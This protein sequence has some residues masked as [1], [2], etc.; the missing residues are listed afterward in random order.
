VPHQ[1]FR[2]GTAHRAVFGAISAGLAGQAALL[3]SGVVFARLLGPEGRGDLAL[4]LLL[5]AVVYQIGNLGLPIACAYFV[6]QDPRRSAAIAR[7]LQ[8]FAFIQAAALVVVHAAVIATV[9]WPRGSS[10]HIAALI[11]LAWTAALAAQEYGLAFLQGQRRFLSFNVL[12]Q[13]PAFINALAAVGLMV[14]RW[15]DMSVVVAML[16]IPNVAFGAAAL[17]IAFWRADDAPSGTNQATTLRQLI[18]FGAKGMFGSSYPVETFRL[19]QLIV[20]L[21]LTVSDLGLYVVALSFVNLPRFI[22]QSIGFVAY[23]QVA[24]ERNQLRQR[25]AI[26]RFFWAT[27]GITVLVVFGLELFL[28]TL[29]TMFFGNQFAAAVPVSRVL[30]VAAVLLSARRILAEVMKGAGNPAAG[31]IA[32]LASFAALVP[33]FVLFT[34][35]LHLV[36]IGVALTIGAG[37]SLT[38][39]ILLDL[40][41]RRR[42]KSTLADMDAEA[43]GPVTV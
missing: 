8:L 30:L 34:R 29:I 17:F 40:L 18:V 6:A 33:A 15:R 39:L 27:T 26:W 43:D 22:S 28:P 7:Q 19:D 38:V 13:V 9:I 1:F 11:T 3:L 21:F 36:G 25:K 32:E 14:L 16:V 4:L 35:S 2:A 12:R 24:A 31:S 20:G 42:P 5:P 37:I 10:L 23:P 41:G